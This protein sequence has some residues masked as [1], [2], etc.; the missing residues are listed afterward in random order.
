MPTLMAIQLLSIQILAFPSPMIGP[1]I[2]PFQFQTLIVDPSVA[3]VET[4][5]GTRMMTSGIP[6]ARWSVTLS[7]LAIAGKTPAPHCTALPSD[8][9]PHALKTNLP[10]IDL[11]VSVESLALQMDHL[12]F[13]ESL[14]SLRPI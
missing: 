4:L 1:T 7:F 11:R 2:Y 12:N 6:M 10:F 5:M 14:P 9:Q 8:S 13:A 3:L